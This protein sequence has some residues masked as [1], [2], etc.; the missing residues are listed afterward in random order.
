MHILAHFGTASIL[1]SQFS[2]PTATIPLYD[3]QSWTS[4]AY[5]STTTSFT[6]YAIL[7]SV[8]PTRLIQ[9]LIHHITQSVPRPL[10]IASLSTTV[11]LVC[12]NLRRASTLLFPQTRRPGT[13]ID[14]SHCWN[15][16]SLR[17][18]KLELGHSKDG[19][20]THRNQLVS[21]THPPHSHRKSRIPL[22]TTSIITFHT[23]QYH[24]YL[25]ALLHNP[26]LSFKAPHQPTPNI[27]CRC[28]SLITIHHS[29]L[30]IHRHILFNL[31]SPA[32]SLFAARGRAI[33]HSHTTLLRHISARPVVCPFLIL[34]RVRLGASWSSHTHLV[35]PSSPFAVPGVLASRST[36][37]SLGLQGSCITFS[38][39]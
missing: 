26:R 24:Q 5:S 34:P 21:L 8:S 9:L 6:Y 35:L 11:L 17:H 22:P 10:P 14:S 27:R 12:H 15:W 39:P 16:D 2:I 33:L 29:L 37:S 1:N 19:N 30:A 36:L 38:S 28:L 31:T 3:I 23:T 4:P 25:S 7:S 18:W 20:L 13:L 32:P